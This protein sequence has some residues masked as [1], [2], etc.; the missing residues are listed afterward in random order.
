[1]CLPRCRA[2]ADIAHREDCYTTSALAATDSRTRKNVSISGAL[3]VK[4]IEK[5]MG[6]PGIVPKT[7]AYRAPAMSWPSAPTRCTLR[8]LNMG[9]GFSRR[10]SAPLGDSLVKVPL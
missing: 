8:L 7:L 9:T 2:E 4:R 10:I 5:W 6:L 1:M 3:D